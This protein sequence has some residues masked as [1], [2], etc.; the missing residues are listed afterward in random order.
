MTVA[1]VLSVVW[2]A[3][4]DGEMYGFNGNFIYAVVYLLYL[5]P[6]L[7][8]ASA[9]SAIKYYSFILAGSL[10]AVAALWNMRQGYTLS[11][12]SLYGMLA[13]KPIYTIVVVS[14][15]FDLDL[16]ALTQGASGVYVNFKTER[17][18]EA[19]AVIN[20]INHLGIPFRVRDGYSFLYT[21]KAQKHEPE[22]S[23]EVCGD[24]GP[25]L[26]HP[27][28]LPGSSA[29]CHITVTSVPGRPGD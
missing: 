21:A 29:P 27:H 28:N 14:D 18:F 4:Q 26:P 10:V 24:S 2:S 23:I 25:I 15:Q 6:W 3:I 16:K 20:Q 1:V 17:Q 22:L 13:P 8:A 12:K 5:F 9:I 11:W 7:I 19:Y